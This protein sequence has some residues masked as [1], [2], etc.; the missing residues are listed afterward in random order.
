MEL[1]KLAKT[2]ADG[3]EKR[4]FWDDV[5]AWSDVTAA[6]FADPTWVERAF[7]VEKLALIGT[8]VSEAIEEL[9]DG[10]ELT[11][12]Y[13]REDGKPEGVPSELADVLIRV[14]DFAGFHGIDVD[15]AVAEKLAYNETRGHKHGRKF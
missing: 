6:E 14:L 12:T 13:H 3:N 4:G 1:N 11:A 8:E 10:R 15:K 5:T 9:R 2:I 7:A